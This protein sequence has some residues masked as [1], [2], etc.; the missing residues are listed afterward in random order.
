MMA[1]FE[2][3][4]SSSL[5]QQQLD[6]SGEYASPP[7]LVPSQP[8]AHMIGEA[9]PVFTSAS[10]A[11]MTSSQQFIDAV[12]SAVDPASV[13]AAAEFPQFVPSQSFSENAASVESMPAV[14]IPQRMSPP[15]L[16]NLMPYPGASSSLQ[17]ALK[18]MSSR[19]RANTTGSYESTRVATL[20]KA[21]ES[22]SHLP[23]P[24][25]QSSNPLLAGSAM[26]NDIVQTAEYANMACKNSQIRRAS[27]LLKDLKSKVS[28]VSDLI[29]SFDQVSLS[30]SPRVTTPY[31]DDNVHDYFSHPG[32]D[33]GDH[34]SP[35]E[36]RKRCLSDDGDQRS[37]KLKNIK[38]EPTDGGLALFSSLATGTILPQ[39][40]PPSRPHSPGLQAQYFSNTV[41]RITNTYANGYKGAT[42]AMVNS[43][44]PLSLPPHRAA[45]SESIVPTRHS[46][47]APALTPQ[48]SVF[49]PVPSMQFP[50]NGAPIGRM[51]RSGSISNG[52]YAA[53]FTSLESF[54]YPTPVAQDTW[55]APAPA[56]PSQDVSP[57]PRGK[58]AR[59]HSYNLGTVPAEKDD[60]NEE[61]D[62]RHSPPVGQPTT[63]SDI[64]PE[65]RDDVNDIFFKFLNKICSNLDATDAKGE[66]IHQTLMAKKMQR[67]DESPDFRPF[68]F[69]IQ[70]L[71]NAFLE[72]L[73][74]HG[75]PEEKIP[76]KRVRG[77][78]W[79]Q[80][81]ILRYNEDGKKAKSK[82]NHIWNVE[83]KKAGEGKWE[84]RPFHR[85]LAGNPPGVA[86]SGL[87][88]SWTPRVWDPQA[89]WQNVPVT[90]TS[91]WL[92]PWLKWE[93]NTLAGYPP[94]NATSC[95]IT[96]DASFV[97]EG[98]EGHLSHTFTINIA[99]MSSIDP[100]TN[101]GRAASSH[102]LM[103]RVVH[104]P[105]SHPPPH[106]ETS[107]PQRVA[108]VLQDVAHRVAEET[109]VV[110]SRTP[111][112]HQQGQMASLVKQ[113][114]V[115]ESTI[116]AYD[117]AVKGDQN[118]DMLS[119][120]HA[121]QDVVV[122]AAQTVMAPMVLTM[123]RPPTGHEALAN[124]PMS[125]VSAG[126]KGAL[127]HAVIQL[128]NAGAHA[129]NELDVIRT[130]RQV[131]RDNANASA[132]AQWNA[133]F[134][135]M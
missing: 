20:K 85:K 97:F 44:V 64:P 8:P 75:F 102:E 130:A 68:K 100:A 29:A 34:S 5:P 37:V 19:N 118:R 57:Q 98:Q 28:Y 70:A 38:G 62:D 50:P 69:R 101:Y 45:W 113:Q 11:L 10:D 109:N 66:A 83:A 122:E 103:Q 56:P 25:S 108:T 52:T 82:G 132:V 94:P 121:V 16:G 63:N 105:P 115:L 135:S 72:E 6:L 87:R 67:L 131:I 42:E 124:A 60:E 21:H 1:A 17:S 90:Y 76:M 125:E 92:P 78:L 49:P 99:P 24:T 80:P 36:R 81:H 77:Y 107:T 59:S 54:N 89:S 32:L 129:A 128:D 134:S 39:S 116:D 51:S 79:K 47:S 104:Q 15:H 117:K 4:T 7:A 13:I 46:L 41:P 55:T 40:P 88:W 123:S 133:N 2:M 53:P 126:V 14:S 120:A 33:S 110:Q 91:P 12:E 95:E 65:Y 48:D 3:D 74:R 93:N 43:V 30:D 22:S 31:G 35:D 119:L 112:A 71:T 61:E 18:P 86:Y 114:H 106:F 26:L 9:G 27:S 96:V 58:R 111:P 73:A 84:F 127:A 23:E